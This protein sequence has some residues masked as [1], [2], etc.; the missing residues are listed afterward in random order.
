[1]SKDVLCFLLVG[2]LCGLLGCTNDVGTQEDFLTLDFGQFDQQ[3]ESFLTS[4][5]LDGASA[6]IVHKDQGIVHNRG[7]GAFAADRVYLIASSSKILSVGILMRLVD[8]GLLDIDAPISNYLG[9]W[10]SH[11]TD[12]T[13]AQL[14]SNSSGLVG[15]ADE[16][17]YMPYICQF[18]FSDTL[19]NCAMTIY[20]A[21]DQADRITPDTEF[22]YGGGQWQLAG[23]IAEVVSGKSWAQLV[24]ETYRYPCNAPSIGYANHF[25]VGYDDSGDNAGG[26]G[27]EEESSTIYPDFFQADIANLPAT[28]NPSIEGG[29]HTNALDYGKVLLMHLRGGSCDDNR[30]LSEASVARMQQDRIGLVYGG[31]TTS[32]KLEGYGMG[33]WID[34]DFPGVVADGGMYGAIPWLDVSREYGALILMEAD[35]T[36]GSEL[37]DA[38]KP[39]VDAAFDAATR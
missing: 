32:T 3:V 17:T 19:Q 22:H 31:S 7:Y 27:S 16:P 13:V 10:G 18:V 2:G 1:M 23:G 26:T 12:I 11:K 37:M 14:V 20:T 39:I 21:D 38:V 5:A 4:H 29:G 15:L 36:L 25:A 30:V 24:H 28:E 6:V 9:M 34:R 35:M 33:W 8:Q